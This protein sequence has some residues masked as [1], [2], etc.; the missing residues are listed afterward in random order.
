MQMKVVTSDEMREIDRVTIEKYGIPGPVLMERSGLAVAL[1]VKELYSSKKVVVL[2]GSGNNGGDGLVA[3]RNLHNM[4]FRVNILIFAPKDALSPDCKAQYEI[5]KKIGVPVEFRKGINRRDIHGSVVIDAVFGTGLSR[6]V[7]GEIAKIFTLLNNSD[8]HVISVDIPSGISSDTGKILGQAIKADFTITFGLPKRG[9]YLY[10]G[11]E[12]TG[13][14]FVEDIGFPDGLLSSNKIKVDLIEK[15]FITGLIPQRPKYSHKGDY[16]HVLVVAGSKGKTG[17][18]LMTAKA[19]MRSGAG[20]VTIGVPESLMNVF[21]RRVTEEMTLPLPDDG[22]GMLSANSI[23]TI[24]DFASKKADVVAVGPGIGVSS[25][26]EKIV[27]ELVKKSP[28][29]IVIDADGINC[30]KGRRSVLKNAKSPVILTPHPGEMARLLS[31]KSGDRSQKSEV[32]LRKEIEQD[33]I[34]MAVS[35]AKGTG[36]YVVLKGVPTIVSV[37]EGNAYINTTGN[38]G[39]ATAGSGDVLTGIIASL[40]GQGLNPVDAS[41]LGVY[42]HGLAGDIAAKKKGEHSLIASDIINSLPAAFSDI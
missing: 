21:Q 16:G 42:L 32:E 14:L 19:C 28:L 23:N 35:F 34:N 15:E 2:C 30:L 18:A 26:T 7:T 41:I 27:V 38:P 20:L 13:K 1:R 9:H 24:L 31:Q 3:A 36:T 40:M 29:P 6:I 12:Y 22:R 33:R 25:D 8:T 10:P 4:G 11:A 5:A 39:M 37:P 17:A